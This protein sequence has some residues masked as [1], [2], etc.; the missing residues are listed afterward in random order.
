MLLL[1]PSSH[2]GGYKGEV[3][4]PSLR[5]LTIVVSGALFVIALVGATVGSSGR[6]STT[7]YLGSTDAAPGTSLR[8]NRLA[9]VAT[10]FRG[11][12]G[13]TATGGAGDARGA[14]GRP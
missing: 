9:P 3:A 8:A 5:P 7:A 6:S 12:L 11:G 10:T 14:G 13:I 4:L 2:A 1:T